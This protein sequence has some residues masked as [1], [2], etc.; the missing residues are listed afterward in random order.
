MSSRWLPAGPELAR[1]ALIVVGG[2]ILAA[3][4]I[5]QVP[6]LREWIKEQW[7]DTPN[8]VNPWEG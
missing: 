7:G 4:I 1:E 3:L 5:G 6:A 2:A 8:P